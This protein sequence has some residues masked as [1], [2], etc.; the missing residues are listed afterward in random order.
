VTDQPTLKADL[1]RVLRYTATP[2]RVYRS[3]SGVWTK[4]E[5]GAATCVNR[6][7]AALVDSGYVTED[8]RGYFAPT[9]HGVAEIERAAAER[10]RNHATGGHR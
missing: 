2:G 4:N 7:I 1:R 8:S 10:D 5:R 6:H 3:G 9:A